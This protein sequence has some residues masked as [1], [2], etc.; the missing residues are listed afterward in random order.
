MNDEEIGAFIK[1]FRLEKH[2]STF[3]SDEEFK[4]YVKDGIQDI[5]RY[6]GTEIDYDDDLVARRLL[7]NYVLYADYNKLAE[8]KEVYAKDYD[9]LQRYYFIKNRTS[10]V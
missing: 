3:R 9:E 4:E 8:F 10:N 1:A 6:C 2:V 7:K 5:N